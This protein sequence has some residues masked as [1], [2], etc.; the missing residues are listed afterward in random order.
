MLESNRWFEQENLL[1][2]ASVVRNTRRRLIPL[3]EYTNTVMNVYMVVQA[4]CS[5]PKREPF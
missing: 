3:A 1:L 5:V 2:F 4:A